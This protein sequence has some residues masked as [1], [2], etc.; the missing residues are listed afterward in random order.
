MEKKK[1]FIVGFYIPGVYP[2]GRE[3][4][5]ID[6]LAP[7]FLKA[8]ADADAEISRKYDIEL[9]NS[10]IK[11]DQ[12]ELARKISKE[13]PSFVG[14]STYLWNYKETFE[15][16]GLVKRMSPKTKILYGGPQVSD[17]MKETMEEVSYL[18]VIIS[19]TG[20]SRFKDLLKSEFNSE[21]LEQMS[22]IAFRKNN[23]EIIITNGHVKEDVSKIPSPYKTGAINLD[24]GKKHTIT[25]ETFRGCPMQCAY[26][27]WGDPDGS[28]QKFPL[29]QILEDIDIIFNNPNV[30]YAILTDANLFYTSKKHWEPVIERIASSSRKIPLVTNLDIRVMKPEM[31][32]ALSKI[33]LGLGQYTFGMQSTNPRA[34]DLANR[35]CSEETWTEKI[36]MIRKVDPESKI[37]M[38]V[39][40]GLPGDNHEGFLNTVDFALGLDP[41]KF[42]MFPLLVLPGTPFWEK[43]N[44]YNFEIS[45]RPDYLIKSNMTYS[46]EDMQKTFE[47]A[48]WFQ[49]MQRFKAIQDALVSSANGRKR[50]DVI[51]DYLKEFKKRT[52]IKTEEEFKYTLPSANRILRSVMDPTIIPE[53]GIK[54]YQIAKEFVPHNGKT[55]DLQLGIDY[56][57]ERK[58]KS[59]E[60]VDSRFIEQFGQ[61]KLSQIKC[62]WFPYKHSIG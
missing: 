35:K 52:G 58:S 23:G 12:M 11:D 15:N 57:T 33:E 19:G 16:S 3:D 54:A 55:K 44:E 45:E 2:P 59:A 38:E 62:N 4:V 28:T 20:E 24:D 60:D 39:I 7:A 21:F 14:Y 9:I 41:N 46:Q 43:R 17:L 8:T 53:N 6:M 51:Q 18:D 30:E 40:Y 5:Q 29:E 61:R 49:T 47:F 36:N 22:K 48:T 37:C 25:M 10:S 32:K 34:L 31:I 13:T 56:Y 27:Q 1:G 50:I 26:C 42:Y